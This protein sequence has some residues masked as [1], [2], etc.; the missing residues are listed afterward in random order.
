MTPRRAKSATKS[1]VLGFAKEAVLLSGHS[2]VAR[3]K[4]SPTRDDDQQQE[5]GTG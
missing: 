4:A 2:S 5:H 1:T 3:G